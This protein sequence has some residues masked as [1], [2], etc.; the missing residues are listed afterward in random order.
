MNLEVIVHQVIDVDTGRE[1][2]EME[3]K[4]LSFTEKRVTTIEK[5]DGNLEN[6]SS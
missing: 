3:K 5:F 1:A 6:V 2:L 4:L